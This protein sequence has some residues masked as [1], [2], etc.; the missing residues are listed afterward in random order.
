[1]IDIKEQQRLNEILVQNSKNAQEYANARELCAKAKYKIDVLIGA[2]YLENELN[3]RVAYDKAFIIVACESE[4]NKAIYREFIEHQS[5]Y[6]G[7]E[8][9]IE[10]N[11]D[12]VRW[13][14]SKMKYIVENE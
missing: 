1:M 9:I 3:N 5:R 2:K 7:L 14:Q 4:E 13:A 8:K 10:A 12:Q 11:A 6:K